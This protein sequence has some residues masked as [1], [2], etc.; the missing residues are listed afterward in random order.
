V[1]LKSLSRVAKDALKSCDPSIEELEQNIIH[2]MNKMKDL[3]LVESCDYKIYFDEDKSLQVVLM[4]DN[5]RTIFPSPS[6]TREL[7]A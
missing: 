3:S 4:E 7:I 1:K 2:G 6:V 5:T